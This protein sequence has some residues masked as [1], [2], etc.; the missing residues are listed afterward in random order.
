M[1][2]LPCACASVRRASRLLSQLYDGELREHDL[3]ATQYALLGVLS[4]MPGRSQQEIGTALGM[5]KTTLSRNLQ[6]L[7]RRG[8]LETVAGED[9]R[10]RRL[11]LSPQGRQRLVAAQPSWKRAQDR[12]KR[13]LSAA[14]WAKVW[15]AIGLLTQA[16]GRATASAGK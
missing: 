8:W 3:E 1:V 6:L 9:A 13:E 11:Q 12:V 5:D 14:E 16:A 4:A 2:P 10:E 15:E 7:R